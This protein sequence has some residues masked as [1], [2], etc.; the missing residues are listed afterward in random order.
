MT[1]TTPSLSAPLNFPLPV[2]QGAFLQ[3]PLLLETF[4]AHN[5]TTPATVP[6][7]SAGSCSKITPSPSR[8]STHQLLI[9]WLNLLPISSLLFPC[10]PAS[11]PNYITIISPLYKPQSLCFP[12]LLKPP[13][14]TPILCTCIEAVRYRDSKIFLYFYN[15]L[16]HSPRGHC[17]T[18]G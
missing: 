9:F 1:H 12:P 16:P 7:T 15:S 4:P 5:Q 11:V 13:G 6:L 17:G 8:T 3:I 18:D 10:Y 14:K 2:K